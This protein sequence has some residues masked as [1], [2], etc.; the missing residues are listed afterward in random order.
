MMAMLAMLM[1]HGIL[2][3]LRTFDLA[4]IE[5]VA[6]SWAAEMP[7]D[8]AIDETARRLLTLRPEIRRLAVRPAARAHRLLLI[9]IDACPGRI[10]EAGAHWRLARSARFAQH[11]LFGC[12]AFLGLSALRPQALSARSGGVAS[13]ISAAIASSRGSTSCRS[14]PRRRIAT[15]PSSA[16]RLPTTR[17]AGTLARLCSRTL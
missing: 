7:A 15:V 1:M 17:R 10:D 13:R 3:S 14:L 9:A 8:I 11:P 6:A 2:T 4:R 16:S 5:R 12:R